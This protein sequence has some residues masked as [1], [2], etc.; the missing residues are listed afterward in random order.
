MSDP[1]NGNQSFTNVSNFSNSVSNLNVSD[2]NVINQK[3]NNLQTS[4]FQCMSQI[5]LISLWTGDVDELSVT[6]NPVLK[7]GPQSYYVC[8][9][10]TVTTDYL[11]NQILPVIQG[12]GTGIDSYEYVMYLGP[13]VANADVE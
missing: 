2:L 12:G 8:N 5:G 1:V 4:N 3:S 11:K 13:F 9:G 7:Q 6:S 10:A